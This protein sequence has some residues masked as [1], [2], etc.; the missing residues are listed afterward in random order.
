MAGIQGGSVDGTNNNRVIEEVPY[1]CTH[2]LV[3]ES[4]A[5]EYRI[6]CRF[7]VPFKLDAEGSGGNVVSNAQLRR[8]LI[9]IREVL[10]M[11][12]NMRMGASTIKAKMAAFL[13]KCNNAE[14][15]GIVPGI[16]ADVRDSFNTIIDKVV[17]PA[18]ET[19]T[20]PVIKD[21]NTPILI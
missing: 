13:D 15:D 7:G 9:Y 16:H 21:P 2:A 11:P 10:T 3:L 14:V 19:T 17:N 8:S 5:T 1:D 20:T 12:F 6:T 4:N 18:A